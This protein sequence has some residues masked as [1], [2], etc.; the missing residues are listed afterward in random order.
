MSSY[1][2][3]DIKRELNYYNSRQRELNTKI[4]NIQKLQNVLKKY[5]MVFGELINPSKD[6]FELSEKGEQ[7]FIRGA[8]YCGEEIGSSEIFKNINDYFLEYNTRVNTINGDLEGKIGLCDVKIQ[9]FEKELES[10][11]NS[12]NYY[13]NLNSKISSDN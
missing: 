13:N 3:D 6:I 1:T 4:E 5:N 2:Q 12:I 10:V 8:C 7:S 11:N 9:N